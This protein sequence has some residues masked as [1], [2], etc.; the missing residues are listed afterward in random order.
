VGNDKAF[1]RQGIRHLQPAA[2]FQDSPV[3]W[4]SRLKARLQALIGISD[5]TPCLLCSFFANNE[6]QRL[7]SAIAKSGKW[8]DQSMDHRMEAARFVSKY[9]YD[10]D[11]RLLS[12]VLSKPPDRVT[13]SRLTPLKRDCQSNTS[14]PRYFA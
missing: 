8:I 13:Y 9:Y 1:R 4:S 12:Y 6:I 11:P 14:S 5:R 7:V 2:D 3:G 10:Q